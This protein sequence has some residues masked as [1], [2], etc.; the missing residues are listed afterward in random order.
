MAD[1]LKIG[2]EVK[3]LLEKHGVG[4]WAVIFQDPDSDTVYSTREGNA[5]VI[6]FETSGMASR[7]LQKHH[8][9]Q[10]E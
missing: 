7:I 10:E 5:A 1:I 8:T 2:D 6:H 4:T 9:Y 3:E